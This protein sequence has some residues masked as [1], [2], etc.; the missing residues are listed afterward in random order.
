V[1]G[2]RPD[3]LGEGR[4]DEEKGGERGEK[5]EGGEVQGENMN[6]RRRRRKGEGKGNRRDERKRAEIAPQRNG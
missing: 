3:S 5:G 4:R 2:L 6:R 1:A